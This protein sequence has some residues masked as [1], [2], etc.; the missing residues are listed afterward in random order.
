MSYTYKKGKYIITKDGVNFALTKEQVVELQILLKEIL[1][2]I[3]YIK[4]GAI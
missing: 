1:K 2:G 4:R 3:L